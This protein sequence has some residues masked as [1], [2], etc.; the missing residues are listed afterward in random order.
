MV[1]CVGV[2]N[3]TVEWFSLQA[4]KMVDWCSTSE[5]QTTVSLIWFAKNQS[6]L[7]TVRIHLSTTCI[8]RFALPIHWYTCNGQLVLQLQPTCGSAISFKYM[9]MYTI[10]WFNN[11]VTVYCVSITLLQIHV[12]CCSIRATGIKIDKNRFGLAQVSA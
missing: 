7:L 8:Y 11:T 2:S 4:N 10:L 1:D 12:T 5:H 9:Y 6:T 3:K